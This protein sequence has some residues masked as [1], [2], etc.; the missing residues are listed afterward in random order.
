[1]ANYNWKEFLTKWSRELLEVGYYEDYPYYYREPPPEVFDT[2]WIGYPGAT[3]E[4]LIRTEERLGVTLPPSYREFLK[5]SNGWRKTTPFI[6]KLW[7]AE[8]VDWFSSRNQSWIDA[9]T[10]EIIPVPD[11]E[12][13]VYG[14]E[15][16]ELTLRAEYLKTALEISDTGDS[17]IYLLNPQIVTPA[18]EWEA[19][20]FANWMPG[21][22]R[23]HSFWEM[24]QAEY[25]SFLSMEKEE[26]QM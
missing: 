6:D 23:Y 16:S 26:K 3:E 8:E 13:F 1:M 10:R 25:G 11:E 12:Y 17:A 7:S 24:M 19:W 22:A 15:Q 20:F 5:I 4:Q 2:G 9:W 21:A 18:G 14:E